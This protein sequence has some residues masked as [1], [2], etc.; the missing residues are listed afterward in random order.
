MHSTMP[1]FN[2]RGAVSASLQMLRSRAL[3]G[4]LSHPDNSSQPP[5]T[6]SAELVIQGKRAR[7]CLAPS[8]SGACPPA[9]RQ[10]AQARRPGP[11]VVLR[12]TYLRDY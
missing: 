9:R 7:H 11:F 8:R 1:E 4:S 6:Q 10:H 3:L 12:H 2:G 5:T